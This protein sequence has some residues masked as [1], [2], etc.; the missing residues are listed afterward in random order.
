[1]TQQRPQPRLVTTGLD[2]RWNRRNPGPGPGDNPPRCTHSMPPITPELSIGSILVMQLARMEYPL[3]GIGCTA[4]LMISLICPAKIA[5]RLAPKIGQDQTLVGQ[6]EKAGKPSGA[7][8]CLCR[9]DPGSRKRKR[10]LPPFPSVVDVNGVHPLHPLETAFA[11][12]GQPHRKAVSMRDYLAAHVGG[13]QVFV[14]FF[15]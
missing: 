8:H 15:Q 12:G 1:M 14:S 5:L 4:P 11:R 6:T 9:Y 10:R 13:Q 2:L 7:G 3:S